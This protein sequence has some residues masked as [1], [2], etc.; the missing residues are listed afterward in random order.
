[1]RSAWLGQCC[2]ALQEPTDA[3]EVRRTAL[4]F[5][6]GLSFDETSAGNLG[7]VVTEAATNLLKHAGGGQVLL[8]GLE[9][10]AWAAVEM[11]AVDKGPGIADLG[12]CLQDGYSTAGSSGTGLGAIARLSNVHEIYSR[13][14]QGTVVMAQVWKRGSYNG[15][16]LPPAGFQMGGVSV[17]LAGEEE[18]G[19]S[20]IFQE[21]PGFARLVVADGL[22]HG[23][24]AAE[25]SRAA[26]RAAREWPKDPAPALLE[27]IHGALRATR[28]AA[29]AVA[30][31]DLAAQVVRFAG[32]GNVAGTIVPHT[33]PARRLVSIAGTAGHELRKI[34][35]FTYPWDA[36]SL[37]LMHSDGLQS[38][39]SFDPYPGLVE[40]HPSLIAG[41][42]YRDYA[43]GRDDVTVVVVREARE[44]RE[45][46]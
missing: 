24:L 36:R 37:L 8:C 25:A 7:L 40:R 27:R 45:T 31:I 10:G 35:E 19:D 3:A 15:S 13:R 9:S 42:M 12:R 21:R 23:P 32:A 1:V 29:V 38:H 6:S 39:W 43:R 16:P 22:G 44:T 33:G 20:W 5:A 34:V 2:I 18:C 4:A 41:V 17:P 26:I 11:L 30:E 14:D 28:G 46:L